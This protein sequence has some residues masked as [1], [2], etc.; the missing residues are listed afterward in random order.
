[1]AIEQAQAVI[2]A[3]RV[4]RYTESLP[5][6]TRDRLG[7]AIRGLEAGAYL[8]RVA[9]VAE[10]EG[11][12]GEMLAEADRAVEGAA[13]ALSDAAWWSGVGLQRD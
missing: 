5:E 2:A 9:R 12:F 11:L 7:E 10:S 3:E 4:P 1:M 8:L 6:E 13:G